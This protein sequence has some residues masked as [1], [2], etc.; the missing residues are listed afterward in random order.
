MTLSGCFFG[1]SMFSL[2]PNASKVALIALAKRMHANGG[3]LIDC[4][5]R[6]EHLA[7]MGGCHISYDEFMKKVK[8]G[9]SLSNPDFLREP[10]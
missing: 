9:A 4:Q 2:V 3:V 1:E 6:T 7:S 10:A 5:Y 8:V